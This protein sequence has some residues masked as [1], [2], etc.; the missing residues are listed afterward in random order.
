MGARVLL[1]KVGLD[2]HDRGLHVVARALRDAGFEVILAPL[3][4]TA[5]QIAQAA[6][7]E[8]ARAVGLSSLSGAHRTHFARVAQALRDAGRADVIL[9]GGG[10][11]P[12]EDAEALKREGFRM[13]FGPG[14]R[15][16]EIVEFLRR[17]LG[18]DAPREAARAS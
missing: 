4:Q 12:P 15:M 11:I 1:G 16:Q 7:Q 13:L 6:V 8:D 14:T 17:T 2:G 18:P 9:F 10:I 5:G 3:R